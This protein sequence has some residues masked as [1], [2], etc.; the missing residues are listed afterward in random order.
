MLI[1]EAPFVVVDTE[2]TGIQASNDRL[3]EIAAV[4]VQG[5]KIVDRFSS[6]INPER[7]VPRRIADMTGIST[8]MLFDQP[9]ISGV[10]P[11]FEHFLGEGIF[12]AHNLT[13]DLGFVNAERARLDQHPL[14]NK[15]LCTLR[16]ARRLLTGLPSKGLSSVAAFYRIPIAGRHRAMGDAAATAAILLRFLVLLEQDHGIETL[17]EILTFQHRSYRVIKRPSESV[18]RIKKEVL[19]QLP[20]RPGVYYMKD[21]RGEIIYVG[22]AKDLRSRVRSYFNA[23]EAHPLRIRK[24]VRKVREIDWEITGSELGALLLES[25]MIKKLQPSF[26]R[27]QLEYRMHPFIRLDTTHRYPKVSWSSFL[28]NDGAEY[29]GPVADRNQA[30][31]VVELINR[32]YGLRECDDET[33]PQRTPCKNAETER[34]VAPCEEEIPTGRYER[35]VQRVRDFLLGKDRSV[36][37]QLEEGM[38]AAAARLEFETAGTYRDWY[39]RLKHMLD[40]QHGI[41]APVLS[42]NAVL[43]LPGKNHETAQLLFVRFGR[44]VHTVELSVPPITTRIASLRQDLLFHF[45]DQFEQPARYLQRESDEIHILVNWMVTNQDSTRQVRWESELDP[46]EFLSRILHCVEETSL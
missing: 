24:L 10:M 16:L 30:E 26:N 29:Y 5:G 31:L 1:H 32:Y 28:L 19:P 20:A 39:D 27:M 14:S 34:C 13:F 43:V 22:K 46:G 42:H 8:A 45:N 33:L 35:E 4:R 17:D 36:L 9:T 41:A 38:K 21:A 40:R 2:T 11:A 7:S 44:H 12:V 6:L 3:I 15:T 25:R 37:S 18:Q 23:V